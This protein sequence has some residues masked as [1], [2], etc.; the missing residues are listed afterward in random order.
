MRRNWVC[1]VLLVGVLAEGGEAQRLQPLGLGPRASRASADTVFLLPGDKGAVRLR[2]DLAIEGKSPAANWEA[3]LDRLFD[4]FDRDADG[5]LSREEV[6]RMMPLPL[7]G[8]NELTI[9]FARLDA[10]RD[11]KGSRAE[12]KAFCL[13]NGFTPVVKVVVPPSADDARLAAL[14]LRRLDADGDGKLTTRE[15]RRAPEALGR[16]DLDD[17]ETLDL[18][19]LLAGAGEAERPGP[20]EV[21]LGGTMRCEGVLLQLDCGQ[22]TA[23]RLSG[24]DA[25]EMRLEAARRGPYRLQ[26]PGG[27]WWMTIR[28]RAQVSDFGSARAFLIAQFEEALAGRETLAKADMEADATLSGFLDLLPF[29]DR[30]G[31]GRLSLGALRNYLDLVERGIHA[32]VWVSLADRQGNP[33]RFLDRNGDGRLSHRELS[34]AT[35]LL[36]GRADRIGMPRQFDLS[37]GGP[38]VRSW[39][40]VAVPAPKPAVVEKAALVPTP[41]W[42]RAMDRN[43]DGV[44]SRREFLGPPEVF[45][46]LDADGDGMIS[47]AEA[48]RAVDPKIRRA[49]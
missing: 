40:G 36:A 28:P 34:S 19:E 25:T 7:P 46:R 32:Q 9:D 10:D 12:L 8:G 44:V 45:R 48:T 17:D 30:N 3:F 15:L 2:L 22:K 4:H 47:A 49:P 33:F 37:F 11:G 42:F 43:G 13:R 23:A 1:S 29:A 24:R 6:A 5:S 16:Y 27:R 41:A 31:D 14:F 21:K 35:D 39:G 38:P 26:G 20:V 18:G